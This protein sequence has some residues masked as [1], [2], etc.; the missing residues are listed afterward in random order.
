MR[1]ITFYL[2][3]GSR[4]R[5]RDLKI[6]KR[7]IIAAILYFIATHTFQSI[8]NIHCQL[9]LNFAEDLLRHR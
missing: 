3:L 8:L 2:V 7:K 1:R 6:S 5:S 4:G 9:H